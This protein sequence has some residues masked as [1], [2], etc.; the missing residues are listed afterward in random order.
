MSAPTD[1]DQVPG[2]KCSRSARGGVIIDLFAG[3]G[4]WSEG[5]RSLGLHDFGIEFDAAACATRYA[6][7]HATWQAD[8]RTVDPLMFRPLGIEGLIASPPCQSF[9]AAG[10][11]KGLEDERGELVWLPMAWVQVLMPE[12]VAM[13][14]VPEVLPIWKQTARVIE[15]Y[16]YRTWTGV[17]NTADYGV[18]QSR[19]RAI[20]LAHRRRSVAPPAPTHTEKPLGEGLFGGDLQR[21][22]TMAEGLGW[23]ATERPSPT[24]PAGKTGDGRVYGSDGHGSAQTLIREREAG[25]WVQ[26]ERSGDRSE[27]GFDPHAIPCQ[28]ITSKARSWQVWPWERPATTVCGDPRL[29]PPGYR[30]KPTDYAQDGTYKGERSMDEAIRLSAEEALVLQSFRPD[31]PVQ[32]SRTKQFQQIGNAIPPALATAI[33]ATLVDPPSAPASDDFPS[34]AAGE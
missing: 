30:G 13:E 17:L 22:I 11:R 24:I 1:R 33:I 31:Y 16:G 9:S 34:K 21:W 5:L 20:L 14:Q 8:L 7:G 28:T 10:K 18:P 26:R 23:G 29:S 27:E 3:P 2:V 4:G 15:E 25:R 12:W 32:G 19:E 6:A